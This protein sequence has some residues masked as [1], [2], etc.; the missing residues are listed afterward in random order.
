MEAMLHNEE[1]FE[2]YAVGCLRVGHIV[3]AKGLLLAAG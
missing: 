2:L 1:A 3:G